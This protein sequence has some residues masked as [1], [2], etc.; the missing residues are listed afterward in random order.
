MARQADSGKMGRI[1]TE[2]VAEREKDKRELNFQGRKLCRIKKVCSANST[3][4]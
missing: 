3:E 4:I 2:V 1:P